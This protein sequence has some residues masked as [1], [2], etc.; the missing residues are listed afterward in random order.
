MEYRYRYRESKEYRDRVKEYRYR[1][2]E[3]RSIDTGRQ[4]VQ[5]QGV[6]E[7]RYRYRE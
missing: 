2:K 7:Y 6:E 3:S 1:N 5:I 4:G